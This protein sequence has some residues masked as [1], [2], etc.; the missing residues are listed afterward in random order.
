MRKSVN[1]SGKR[2]R[3]STR[4]PLG[5]GDGGRREK[6]MWGIKRRTWSLYSLRLDH[7]QH[8]PVTGL[9]F[10][11]TRG[12]TNTKLDRVSMRDHARRREGLLRRVNAVWNAVTWWLKPTLDVPSRTKNG[13]S[14]CNLIPSRSYPNMSSPVIIVW[15][16]R[17]VICK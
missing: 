7:H 9:A 10:V 15:R 5:E 1:K 12:D 2:P 8:A 6:R 17:S 14:T 4:P 16:A 13:R 11:P 3:L